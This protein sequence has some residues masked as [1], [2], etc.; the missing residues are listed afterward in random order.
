MKTGLLLP[1]IFSTFLLLS[2][3]PGRAFMP[4]ERPLLPN[5]DKRAASAH[6]LDAVSAEQRAAAEQLRARLPQVRV[7]FDPLLGAPKLISAGEEFLSGTNGRGKA[8]S[9]AV[10]QS[11]AND[12]HAV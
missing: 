10:A 3:A 7:D 9:A 1:A 2:G 12:P 8:I 4:P 5:F 11:F 6:N